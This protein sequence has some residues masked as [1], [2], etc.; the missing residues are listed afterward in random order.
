MC[1]KRL[2]FQPAVLLWWLCELKSCVL[3][4]R[5]FCF[6]Y[7]NVTRLKNVKIN[8]K[9][10]VILCI[11]GFS[12]LRQLLIALNNRLLVTEDDELNRTLTVQGDP[13]TAIIEVASNVNFL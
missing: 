1:L 10:I 8:Q 9:G 5:N 7:L 12:Y 4:K 11:I 3:P 2:W 13:K 6:K